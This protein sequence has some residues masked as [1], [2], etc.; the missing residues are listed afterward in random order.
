MTTVSLACL[1][2]VVAVLAAAALTKL[3]QRDRVRQS[4]RD[5]GVPD[6]FSVLVVPAEIGVSV[7]LL[8][9]P[10]V[11]AIAAVMLLSAFTVVLARVIRSGR[12]VSCGCFGSTASAPVSMISLARNGALIVL[13]GPAAFAPRVTNVR[14][15]EFLAAGVIGGGVVLAGLLV[16]ALAQVRAHTGSLFSLH[17]QLTSRSEF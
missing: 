3:G 13:C 15:D 9:M 16:G 10:G 7:L 17:P 8:T 12:T 2:T 1:L 14:A 4:T 11:G 6:Y 5:L